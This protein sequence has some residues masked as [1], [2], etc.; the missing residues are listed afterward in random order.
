MKC[1]LWIFLQVLSETFVFLRR[2]EE[3]WYKIC[4]GFHVKYLVFL[5]GLSETWEFSSHIFD[6]YS[7][8]GFFMKIRTLWSQ[9][10]PCGWTDTQA[11]VTKLLVTQCIPI[12]AHFSLQPMAHGVLQC[13]LVGLLVLSQALF[14]STKQL[15]NLMVWQYCPAVHTLVCGQ[16]SPWR[17]NSLDFLL[18]NG[19][20]E[21]QRVCR[22]LSVSVSLH[23]SMLSM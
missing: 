8:I 3:D 17:R 16:T 6:K 12:H 22:L 10:V 1:V 13:L 20:N 9:V 19:L 4:T 15:K 14:E 7:S 23:C 5:S 18:C 21:W 11:D 2:N